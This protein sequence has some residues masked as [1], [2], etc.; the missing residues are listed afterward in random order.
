MRLTKI[1]VNNFRMLKELDLDLEESLSLVIGKNNCGKT[2]LISVLDKFIGGKSSSNNFTYDD[3]NTSFKTTLLKAIEDDGVSWEATRSK[4]IELYLFIRYDEKDNLS[5]IR[6]LFFDLDPDNSMVVLKFEYT[7]ESDRL[8]SL[9]EAFNNYYARF[10]VNPECKKSECFNIFIKDRHRRYFQIYKKAIRYDVASDTASDGEY[11]FFD[12]T[13]PLDVSKIFSF[14]YIGARRDTENKDNDGTLSSLSGKYYEKTKPNEESPTIQKFE[15]ALLET[16]ISLTEIYQGLFDNV[17]K[18]VKRFGGIRENETIVRFISTLS[19][20]QLLKGNTTVVYK[21]DN[22]QLPESYN[23]LGYLNL[24]SMI[25]EIETLLSEF[26]NDKDPAAIPADINLLFV[27][28]PEAHTHPQMQYIFIKNI[29]SL[30]HEG[31]SGADDKKKIDLQTVI[32]T[33]SS[34]IVAECDFDDIKYFQ[35]VTPSSVISKNLKD[36]DIAYKSEKMPQNNHFKFLKQYLTLNYAEIFFADKAI[37]YEGETERILLPAMMKKTD[38]EEN[39]ENQAPLLSQNISLIESGAYSQIFDKFLSFIGIK[40]LIITD[41]DAGKQ[42]IEI[43]KDGKEKPVIEACPVNAGTHTTNGALKHY[44]EV[45]LSQHKGCTQLTFFT[46]MQYEN[47]VLIKQDEKWVVNQ[48]GNLMLIFQ[49]KGADDYYPRS[50]ED[51]FFQVNRSFIID[52]LNAFLSLKNK[53]MFERKS[54]EGKY[55]F[56]P[57][58]LAKECID[59]KASFA[60]DVLLNS[61][62]DSECSYSNWETPSYIKEGLLWLRN[63]SEAKL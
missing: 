25:I 20:Q 39:D 45:P 42:V 28:E 43:D 27:E 56:N 24:I 48:T 51:S 40:T 10:K 30:L 41:I 8:M 15:D 58:D 14:K 9:I 49:T 57:Y 60:L 6:P 4:G 47:K 50:F 62:K 19:Q 59:S 23:G 13:S 38:E 44:Y 32:T 26:R 53:S 46:D 3:F 61:E 18:K 52:N 29:K 16:D 55:Q 33:H 5:N 17:I 37:L 7:L 2:S 31:A 54:E 21:A 63:D 1:Q 11:K 22:Y 35:R 12:T 36:L 34:H